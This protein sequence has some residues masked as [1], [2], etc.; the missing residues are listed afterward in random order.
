MAPYEV[1]RYGLNRP[2][3]ISAGRASRRSC[4]TA[5]AVASP[6]G[7]SDAHAC[8][9][10]RDVADGR[11]APYGQRRARGR[12]EIGDAGRE[13]AQRTACLVPACL[14]E[15]GQAEHGL[16]ARVG[17][18]DDQ[19]RRRARPVGVQVVAVIA[20]A[21]HGA[22]RPARDPSARAGSRRSRDPHRRTRG[23]PPPAP[24][25]CEP[26]S[27]SSPNRTG[28]VL[29][30]AARSGSACRPVASTARR[31]RGSVRSRSADRSGRAATPRPRRDCARRRTRASAARRRPR[32]ARCHRRR[33]RLASRCCSCCRSRRRRRGC[34]CRR[35]CGWRTPT[36]CRRTGCS[37]RR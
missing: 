35:R 22:V 13:F 29:P 33:R 1:S 32:R 15:G 26:A 16:A 8:H 10:E 21:N 14:H 6:A 20:T 7:A 28:R 2:A 12:A 5:A 30:W 27:T 9:I 24:R 34:S 3:S 37:P 17:A 25:S 36:A 19:P 23:S 11:I 4:R 31:C 18:I